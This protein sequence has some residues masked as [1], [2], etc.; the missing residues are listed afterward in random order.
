[1]YMHRYVIYIELFIGVIHVESYVILFSFFFYSDKNSDIPYNR[2]G[3]SSRD[4]SI[5]SQVSSK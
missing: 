3:Y 1:M 5:S 2:S 4:T